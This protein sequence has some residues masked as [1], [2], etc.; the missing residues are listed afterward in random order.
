M[1]YGAE[2]TGP[3]HGTKPMVRV[4]CGT[5]TL[6]LRAEQTGGGMAP[7]NR[8]QFLR[9]LAEVINEHMNLSKYEPADGWRIEHRLDMD[10][11]TG[12]RTDHFTFI[13]DDGGTQPAGP[14]RAYVEPA[15]AAYAARLER[16]LLDLWAAWKKKG[17]TDAP[18]NTI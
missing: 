15:V 11:M 12:K 1:E 8:A 10:L 9:D 7:A 6:Q 13:A 17:E 14:L 2:Y 3:E 18:Q 16:H 5:V 4:A